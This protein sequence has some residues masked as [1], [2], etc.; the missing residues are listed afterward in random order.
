MSTAPKHLM[1]FEG[2]NALAPH[3]V[4]ALLPKLQAINPRIAGVHARHVHW[5]ALEQVLN[6]SQQDKLA[7]LLTYGERMRGR[8]RGT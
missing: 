2:G 4:Q 5:V 8:P 7:A 1:H 6:P 3:Q